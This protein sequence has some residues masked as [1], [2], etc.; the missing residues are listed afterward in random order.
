VYTSDQTGVAAN[1]RRITTG[2]LSNTGTFGGVQF[3]NVALK[4]VEGQAYSTFYGAAFQ[5]FPASYT[6]TVFEFVRTSAGT[7]S[8]PSW[9]FSS[10]VSSLLGTGGEYILNSG[11][12]QMTFT[13]TI[14]ITPPTPMFA[15][16]H[17]P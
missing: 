5:F 15:G 14:G 12:Q 9:D 13:N 4:F 10:V 7:Y 16:A 17:L 8:F 6:G 3:R 11:A 1:T 2:G